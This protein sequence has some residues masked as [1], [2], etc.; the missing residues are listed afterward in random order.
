MTE[1]T[2]GRP[3]T[4]WPLESWQREIEATFRPLYPLRIRIARGNPYGLPVGKEFPFARRKEEVG[5]PFPIEVISM[6]PS[7]NALPPYQLREEEVEILSG[8]NE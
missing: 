4:P 2:T 8:G 6:W 7:I 1:P 5:S 3:T